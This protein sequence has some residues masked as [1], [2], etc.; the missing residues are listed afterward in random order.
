M[1]IVENIERVPDELRKRPPWVAWNLETPKQGRKPTKRPKN[2]AT[3]RNAKC[4]D[5]STWGSFD[6]AIKMTE[7]KGWSG[8]G[9]EFSVDDPFAGIDLDGCRDPETGV[10]SKWAQKIIGKLNSYSEV[11]PSM[12]GVKIW[13]RGGSPCENS[14]KQDEH[15]TYD[16]VTDK[17]S[18]GIEM[19]HH[20][21]FFCVT[22]EH[23]EGTP[24]TIEYRQADLVDVWR[25]FFGDDRPQQMNLTTAEQDVPDWL[26]RKPVEGLVE[27]EPQVREAKR[28]DIMEA[29]AFLQ[30]LG[31]D[32]YDSYNDWLRVGMELHSVSSGPGML[33]VWDEWSQNSNKYQNGEC[34]ALWATFKADGNGK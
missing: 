6:A 26:K 24:T 34:G 16:A 31:K 20:G 10:I 29:M 9:F 23:V 33:A 4:N 28:S 11:S 21:R 8:V 32:D 14:G 17:K 27:I 2:P 7:R 5:A 13:V 19:Y 1:M 22:G 25:E 18:P 30:T 12:T 15:L 3:G